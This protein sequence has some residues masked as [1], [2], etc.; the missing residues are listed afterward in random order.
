M[1]AA[2]GRHHEL[3]GQVVEGAVVL[4]ELHGGAAAVRVVEAVGAPVELQGL[5]AVQLAKHLVEDGGGLH[6]AAVEVNLGEAVEEDVA[7][8]VLDEAGRGEV[9]ADVAVH[10][11][12]GDAEGA[13]GGGEQSRLVQAEA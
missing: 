9:V 7:A 12:R 3:V 10:Q 1:R 2:H 5:H 13:Y 6:P 4:E 8:D 11:L